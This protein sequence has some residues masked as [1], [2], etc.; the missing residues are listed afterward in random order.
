MQLT[1]KYGY[2][3]VNNIKFYK[4]HEA[5]VYA[6]KVRTNVVFHYHDNVWRN[7]NLNLL[8]K[9]PL[10]NLY[11]ERA[12]QI[13]EKYDYLVLYYS[14]GA[15]SHNVLKTFIDNDIKLDEIC[16]KWPKTL[17]NGNLYTPNNIDTTGKNYWSE[18]NYAIEPILKWIAS[19][20]P[21]IKIT[22]KDYTDNI[23]SLNFEKIFEELNFIRGGGVLLNSV[24]SDSDKI[25][26]DKNKKIAHIY[27]IDKPMIFKHNEKMYMFFLDSCLDQAGRSNVDIES[28]ECFYWTPDFPL[29]PFE[30]A[31]QLCVYFKQNKLEQDYIWSINNKKSVNIINQYLND[32]SRNVL[33]DN[34]DN[35]FQADKPNETRTDKFFWFYEHPELDL[36]R[37]KY[38]YSVN[39][40]LNKIHSNL[41]TSSSDKLR[42][43]NVCKTNFFYVTEAK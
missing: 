29:L 32:V 27:G 31:Y 16:V 6:S 30:M 1:E 10:K 33:Y 39:S 19:N 35:R 25:I 36:V 5:L 24:I 42:F 7:F 3:S 17:M 11:K 14:G 37:Q 8:G 4:K 28:T 20:R 40:R 41:L 15:D 38:F 34:W 23:N 9:V 21:E 18:W 12:N 13:R 2:W 22:I 43:Y 26:T